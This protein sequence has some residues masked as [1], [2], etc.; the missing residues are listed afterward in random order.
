M[1]T[2]VLACLASEVASA[3]EELVTDPL[4]SGD[5][6]ALTSRRTRYPPVVPDHRPRLCHVQ[7]GR[8]AIRV[9][10]PDEAELVRSLDVPLQPCSQRV[11]RC[12][13]QERLQ[14]GGPNLHPPTILVLQDVGGRPLARVPA[15]IAVCRVDTVGAVRQ[16]P[17]RQVR[18]VRTRYWVDHVR[19][20]ALDRHRPEDRPELP[21]VELDGVR[22]RD[23]HEVGILILTNHDRHVVVPD[24][25][26]SGLLAL[27]D[28][29]VWV[30]ALIR[31]HDQREVERT[32]LRHV[33]VLVRGHRSQDGPFREVDADLPCEFPE[34]VEL[35][36]ELVPVMAGDQVR[37]LVRASS[38]AKVMLATLRPL[39]VIPEPDLRE[40][41]DR[42]PDLIR[43]QV[44][45]QYLGLVSLHVRPPVTLPYHTTDR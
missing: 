42:A 43:V 5:P 38:D 41:L 27:V 33:P 37:V 23:L 6:V 12:R 44:F 26:G 2:V 4:T 1:V 10:W 19:P 13:S 16:V 32:P 20:T 25:V 35:L 29:G 22:T 45:G 34:P 31:T 3:V 40:A 9:L 7:E 24:P 28:R 14:A 11:W 21:A 30:V 36:L 17:R 39:E 18:H 15:V 8:D